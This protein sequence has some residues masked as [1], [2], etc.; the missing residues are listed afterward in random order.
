MAGIIYIFVP[1][2]I[3]DF[4]LQGEGPSVVRLKHQFRSCTLGLLRNEDKL[5]EYSKQVERTYHALLTV[6]QSQCA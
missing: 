2:T 4:A 3:P 6:Q 1:L 5:T